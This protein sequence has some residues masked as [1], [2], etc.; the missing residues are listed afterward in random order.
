[1]PKAKSLMHAFGA[2]CIYCGVPCDPM[3]YKKPHHA[4]VDHDVPLCRG[5]GSIKNNAVLACALC[6]GAKGD[7]TGVEFLHLRK[8]GKLSASYIEFLQD[9]LVRVLGLKIAG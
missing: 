9:R 8:T 6:N 1:M 7:M 4:T 3:S 5:G 2:R